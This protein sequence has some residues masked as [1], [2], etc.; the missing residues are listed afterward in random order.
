MGEDLVRMKSSFRTA[1]GLLMSQESVSAQT[2]P[3]TQHTRVY[4][5]GRMPESVHASFRKSVHG[6]RLGDA[7]TQ[8][9]C[10]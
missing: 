3:E 10:F 8:M 7:R 9:F 5:P 6:F 1:R 2:R 4:L